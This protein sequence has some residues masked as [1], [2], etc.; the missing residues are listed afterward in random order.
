MKWLSVLLCLLLLGCSDL[1]GMLSPAD[2]ASYDELLRQEA[3]LE[4]E[5]DAAKAAG[6]LAGISSKEQELESVG[7]QIAAIETRAIRERYGP[8]WG[9]LTMVPIIGPYMQ[10]LGPFAGSLLLPLISKRGRKHYRSALA[11]LTP[12]VT[13]GG[14][15]GVALTDALMDVL[16]AIGL[17]H[18]TPASETAAN[19]A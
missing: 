9:V 18:S 3:Q 13:V 14:E 5:L 15:K 16:K 12:W 17:L 6:D 11:N 2:Q 19:R 4:L 10:H 1:R 7:G 8:F